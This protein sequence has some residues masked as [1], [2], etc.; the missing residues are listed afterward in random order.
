MKRLYKILRSVAVVILVIAFV[1]P[2]GVYV[3]LSVP[4]VQHAICEGV[5][6][7]LSKLLTVDVEIDHVSITPFNRLTLHRVRVADANGDTAMTVRRIG[8]GVELWE[9]LSP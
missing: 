3:A 9:L 7:E 1:L 2:A 6:R 4:S 8:G 5:E